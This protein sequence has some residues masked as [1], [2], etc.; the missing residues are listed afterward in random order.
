MLQAVLDGRPFVEAVR[1]GY[2]Q[3]IQA[4]WRTFALRS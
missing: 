4:L 1:F 3:D 2:H